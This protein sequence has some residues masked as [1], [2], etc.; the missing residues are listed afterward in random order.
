MGK[1]IFFKFV[2]LIVLLALPNVG[3]PAWLYAQAAED[4]AL[5]SKPAKIT[6][7]AVEEVVL[8]PWGVS[9]PARI[10][11]GA[12]FSSL[13]AREI[14]VRNNVAS[15]KLGKRFGGQ[16]LQ[17]PVV[18][19]RYI[20]TSMGTEKRPVVEISVCLGSKLFRTPVTLKDRSEMVYP[21]L[22]GRRTLNG[23]F[24]VDPSISRAAQPTCSDASLASSRRSTPAQE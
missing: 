17:L 24:L 2:W 16:Q 13:D 22:V 18:D 1:R 9:F 21:F 12:D 15:F 6:V 14:V 19:W 7:G 11:T 3:A 20:Q 5:P 10:D 8:N 4:R 23:K